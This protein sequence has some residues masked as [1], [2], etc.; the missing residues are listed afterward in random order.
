MSPSTMTD[1][2]RKATLDRAIDSLLSAWTPWDEPEFEQHYFAVRIPKMLQQSILIFSYDPNVLTMATIE[3]DAIKTLREILTPGELVNLSE[4]IRT[5][6]NE[7]RKKEKKRALWQTGGFEDY[8]QNLEQSF[9]N[10]YIGTIA[11]LNIS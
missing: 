1:L 11:K 6:L 7:N 9:N 10:D 8:S 4:I 2:N 3:K 5:R